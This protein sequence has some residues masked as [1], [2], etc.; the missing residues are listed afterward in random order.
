MSETYNRHTDGPPHLA[1]ILCAN[2]VGPSKSVNMI[3]LSITS[4]TFSGHIY[5]QNY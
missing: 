5:T 3:T 1:S 4:F 2:N